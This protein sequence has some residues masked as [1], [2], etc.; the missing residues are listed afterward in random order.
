MTL[1]RHGTTQRHYRRRPKPECFGAKQRRDHHIAAGAEAAIHAYLD[2]LAQAVAHENRLRLRQSGVL[3][4]RERRRARAAIVTG[5]QHV[6][7]VCLGDA[8]RHRADARFG[9]E[10][11]ADAC[12]RIHLFEIVDELREVLDR[13]DVVVWRR[14]DQRNADDGVP[15]PGDQIGDF[16][17][18]QLS[19]FTRL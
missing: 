10:L 6:I 13:V 12:R 18:G 14:R 4:R 19:A 8:R 17:A 1:P 11:H 3:D 9:D 15:Q 16:V 5:D 2:P 7:G